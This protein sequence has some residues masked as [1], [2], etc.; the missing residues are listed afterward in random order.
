MNL[1][2]LQK[3]VVEILGKGLGINY[4]NYDF[5]LQRNNKESFKQQ[6]RRYDSFKKSAKYASTINNI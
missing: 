6:N 2:Y 1:T 4:Y 3:E 5:Q